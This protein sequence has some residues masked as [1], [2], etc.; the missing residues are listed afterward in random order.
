MH[1]TEG[2]NNDNNMFTD[3]P[4]GTNIEQNQL[5]SVQEEICYTIERAGLEVATANSDTRTQ[6]YAAIQLIANGEVAAGTLQALDCNLTA[7]KSILPT[8]PNALV[9]N[10]G[11]DANRFETVN[12]RTSSFID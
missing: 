11:N 9:F 7:D 4:P 5:N 1:R 2:I 8:V 10:I 3:G 12:I 6:L